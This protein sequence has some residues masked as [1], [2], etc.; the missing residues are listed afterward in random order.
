MQQITRT[1]TYTYSDFIIEPNRFNFLKIDN[2]GHLS[3]VDEDRNDNSTTIVNV[4]FS[5][6]DVIRLK[7]IINQQLKDWN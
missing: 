1:V 3:V 2:K 6:D 4:V 7:D 5:K